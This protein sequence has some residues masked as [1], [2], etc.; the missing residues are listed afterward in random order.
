MVKKFG[1]RSLIIGVYFI[2]K[3]IQLKP[4]LKKKI[5]EKDLHLPLNSLFSKLIEDVRLSS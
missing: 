1:H 5:F 2:L 3:N 4:S